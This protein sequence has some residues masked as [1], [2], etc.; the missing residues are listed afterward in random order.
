MKFRL[1]LSVFIL[2]SPVVW[3][4]PKDS[5]QYETYENVSLRTSPK[6][7]D[8]LNDPDFQYD[9][10]TAKPPQSFLERIL[11]WIARAFRFVAKG[12]KPVEYT[13]YILMFAV[14]LFVLYKILGLD[15]DALVLRKKKILN[16][17][18]SVFEE[19]IHALD[20]DQLI[21]DSIQKK[22][23]RLAVR[24][25]Y[26]KLLKT[27]SSRE[28]IDWEINKTN[29]DYARELKNTPYFEP[30][31]RLTFV[32]EYIWYG[33]FELLAAGFENYRVEFDS[34][35]SIINEKKRP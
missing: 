21:N 19:D 9:K 16:N 7:H 4:S 8:F 23:Y 1:L 17:E 12:G 30:F 33:E 32:F 2:F 35:F 18:I 28:L 29:S 11:N 13:I 10:K 15:Y 26:I 31:T 24:W 5:V 3:A 6:I 14:L 27:L 20:P 22:Q 34:A 25:L